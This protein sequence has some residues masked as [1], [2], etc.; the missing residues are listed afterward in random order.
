MGFGPDLE[1]LGEVGARTPE[2]WDLPPILG[3]TSGEHGSIDLSLAALKTTFGKNGLQRR[4]CSDFP[5][6]VLDDIPAFG[7]IWG[8]GE[9]LGSGRSA[10]PAHKASLFLPNWDCVLR[11]PS[12]TPFPHWQGPA[13][14]RSDSHHRYKIM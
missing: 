14:P 4:S 8:F 3:K 9:N 13:A 11:K 12:P 2:K 1:V 7:E 5:N 6:R 10:W